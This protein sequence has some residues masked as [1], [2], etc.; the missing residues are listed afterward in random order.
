[1]FID[2]LFRIRIAEGLFYLIRGSAGPLRK[3][4]AS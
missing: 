3:K 4:G 1:M 2:I